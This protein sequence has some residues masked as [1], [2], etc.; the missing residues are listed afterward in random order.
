METISREPDSPDPA[1]DVHTFTRRLAAFFRARPHQWIDGRSLEFAGRYAW[2]TRVSDL[3]RAPYF[4]TIRNRQRR[5]AVAGRRF[6]VS[7]YRFEPERSPA[8]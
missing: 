4:M 5:I 6:V 2:R 8:A 3:R 7:E 1:G